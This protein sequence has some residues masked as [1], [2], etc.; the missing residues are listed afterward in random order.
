M[1][2]FDRSLIRRGLVG[3]AWLGLAGASAWGQLD[4]T[5]AGTGRNT[6]DGVLATNVD[7]ARLHVNTLANPYFEGRLPGSRGSQ[8][9][10][11][12]LEAC[13]ASCGLEPAF[14][15]VESSADGREVVTEGASYRQPFRHGT[16]IKVG[17]QEVS[18]PGVDL[19][20]QPGTNVRA[21]GMS[22][23]GSV[24]G[25]VVF[26]GYSIDQGPEGYTS[27]PEGTDLSG[28]V[29]LVL[30]FE[31]MNEEGR[32]LWSPAGGWSPRA[33]LDQKIASATRR[34][35]V[36]VVLVNPPGAD[37]AR[38]NRL[39]DAQGTAGGAAAGV[40]VVQVSMEVAER[41][42]RAADPRGRSLLELRRL[43]DAGG[44][45][46]DFRA[47]VPMTV[48]AEVS[49]EP[50]I[51]HN[52]AG[53]LRGRG[54]LADQYIVVGAHFDHLGL[55]YFGSS[56]REG[57]GK[58]H[59][60]ADDNASGTTGML[61][62]AQR[63][64]EAYAQLPADAEARSII[65]IGFDAEESG[66]NGSRHYVRN[67]IVPLDR[68]YLM[69]NLDMIGR[70][71][72]GVL[73]VHGTGTAEGLAEF[74]KPFFERSGLDIVEKPGGLGP[75]DHASFA[76]AGVPVLFFFTGLH[77]EYHSSRDFP[78]LINAEGLAQV[79]ELA[80]SI[81]MAA[82]TRTEPL[83]FKGAGR[84]EA[85]GNP[86]R[87]RPR[88]EAP[89]AAQNTAPAAEPSAGPARVRVRFGIAP[90]DYSGSEKGVVIGDVYDGTSAAEAGLR[91]GD[92]MIRWNGRPIDTV[93]AWMPLLAEH[94]PGDK[95]TITIV[96]D[97][98]EMTVECTLKARPQAGQ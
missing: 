71:R 34:G 20:V 23:S 26:V 30:R 46:V 36:G 73:E 18:V 58:V 47:D 53:V 9:A 78:W 16:T 75:S 52:V 96:R 37:D 35:A 24:T 80:G 7:L 54:A 11:D 49:R 13:L 89:T 17:R 5:A 66:L 88:A 41:L 63:L 64:S 91:V 57:R 61:I 97:G 14:P 43:A 95:V 81:V 65:F 60:G 68:H 86:D 39:E 79:A 87:A 42:V 85:P 83:P 22:G 59:P 31:P 94:N 1:L 25:P 3:V 48:S 45:V 38:V 29:A 90:G 93:E 28:K 51:A 77:R 12:Y 15:R 67:P 82:A 21:L 70:L 4:S 98:K 74:C 2:R 6:A 84:M 19:G 40:P 92:R 10:L 76:R 56:D 62:I 69:I 32:S 55:G 33:S 8:L 50:V 72:N 44:G 27:Y